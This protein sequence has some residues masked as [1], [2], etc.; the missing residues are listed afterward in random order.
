EAEPDYIVVDSEHEANVVTDLLGLP[1]ERIIVSGQSIFDLVEYGHI[2]QSSDDIAT[3]MLTWKP[4]E[5]KVP[6]FT[7]T[8]NYRFNEQAYSV[9]SKFLPQEN[10][11]IVAHPKMA[12]ALAG[13]SFSD[14]L[15]RGPVSEA[16][17]DT[18]LLI[19]DYSSICYFS[20]FQ[21]AGVIFFQPDLGE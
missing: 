20:F 5:E 13:T 7:S 2:N 9:L 8:T 21:G 18:K 3:I 1:E 14:R 12:Q 15:W 10:I 11:R 6:D 17:K 19:T 16:I 4:Y